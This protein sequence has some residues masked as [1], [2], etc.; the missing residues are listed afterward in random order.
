MGIPGGFRGSAGSSGNLGPQE[1]FAQIAKT[2]LNVGGRRRATEAGRIRQGEGT[3]GREGQEEQALR[4]ARGQCS[5]S[6][7]HA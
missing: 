7:S 2:F 6:Q 4:G 1:A 3:K 5:R